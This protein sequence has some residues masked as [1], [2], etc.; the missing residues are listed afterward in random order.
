MNKIRHFVVYIGNCCY[1]FSRE[2]DVGSVSLNLS[3][4][5]VDADRSR[6]GA[7]EN[8]ILN[9]TNLTTLATLAGPSTSGGNKASFDE[10]ATAADTNRQKVM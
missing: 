9:G 2:V 8:P 7:I 1:A 3:N 5:A 10:C 4:E 6:V